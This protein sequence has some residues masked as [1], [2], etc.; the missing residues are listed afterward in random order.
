MEKENCDL[1]EGNVDTLNHHSSSE[2]GKGLLPLSDSIPSCNEDPVASSALLVD[3][4]APKNWSRQ[5]VQNLGCSDGKNGVGLSAANTKPSVILPEFPADSGFIERAAR[6]SCF[7]GGSFT[8]MLNQFHISDSVNP[9]LQDG[10]MIGSPFEVLTDDGLKPAVGV[11]PYIN[12]QNMTQAPRDVV[13]SVELGAVEVKSTR[14]RVNGYVRP[15]AETSKECYV[16]YEAEA[17]GVDHQMVPSVLGPN[18]LPSASKGQSVKKRKRTGP[19]NEVT[20]IEKNEGV[21]QPE[22]ETDKDDNAKQKNDQNQTTTGKAT[23]NGKNSSRNLDSNEK[24]YIHVRARRGQATNS[25]SLA[26]RVRREKISERMKYLQD[27]VPGCNKVTGKAVMLDEI[28]N[29][30]QSLQRQ[31]EFLSMKLATV[32]PRLDLN[33]EALLTKDIQQSRGSPSMYPYLMDDNMVHAQMHQSQQGFVQTSIPGAGSS[34]DALRRPITSQPMSINGGFKDSNQVPNLWEDE[35]NNV[36]PMNFGNSD[37][38][39]GQDST[40]SLPSGRMKVER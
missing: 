7:G 15:H 35:L 13:G 2:W 27:L 22:G 3:S 40:D 26:E 12:E 33:I 34:V 23:K 32:N 39:N 36:F 20:E 1:E 18:V 25:H 14:Q 8:G 5:N 10:T 37:P 30:V 16:P 21:S 11:R 4:N 29:Y 31:V 6:F 38:S 24:D 28:I 9:Y 19:V 17:C